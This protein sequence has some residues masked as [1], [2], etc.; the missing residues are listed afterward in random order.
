MAAL[1]VALAAEREAGQASGDASD[2]GTGRYGFGAPRVSDGTRP[3]ARGSAH[4]AVG[5]VFALAHILDGFS[6]LNH[7]SKHC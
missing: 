4:S 1:V 6:L 2:Q 5:R 3:S 7:G